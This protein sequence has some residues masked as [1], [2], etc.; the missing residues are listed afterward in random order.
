MRLKYTITASLFYLSPLTVLANLALL[1]S[2]MRGFVGNQKHFPVLH[3]LDGMN[4]SLGE[5][6]KYLAN[7]TSAPK[8]SSLE[9]ISHSQARNLHIDAAYL[10]PLA[11]GLEKC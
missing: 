9:Y 7:V 1:F 5:R 3:L 4:K 2:D 8:V 11:E 6:S 10:Y